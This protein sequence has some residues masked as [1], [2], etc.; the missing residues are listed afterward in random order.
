VPVCRWIRA[1]ASVS[2][3]AV[4]LGF[5]CISMFSA[6]SRS[7]MKIFGR[8]CCRCSMSVFVKLFPVVFSNSFERERPGGMM[9]AASGF[10][11]K[12]LFSCFFVSCGVGS[13]VFLSFGM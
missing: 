7:S 13:V 5:V 1:T 3:L 11:R 9:S 8:F 12:I 2:F 6:I 4:L 10:F